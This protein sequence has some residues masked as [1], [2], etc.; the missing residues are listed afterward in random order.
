MRCWL[1][2]PSGKEGTFRAVDWLV[3]L[4]NLYTKVVYSGLGSGKT[5]NY[6]ISQSSIIN[7]YHQ[8]IE[9]IES[10][11]HIPEKTLHHAAPD[12]QSRLDGL[13]KSLHELWPHQYRRHLMR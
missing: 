6:M 4:M 5:I 2:C 10:D 1:C 3:E 13:R 9:D 11:F 12:I 7:A 8:C